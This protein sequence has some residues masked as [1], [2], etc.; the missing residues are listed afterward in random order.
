MKK[1]CQRPPQRTWQRRHY[2]EVFY[3]FHAE[4]TLAGQPLLTLPGLI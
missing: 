1:T 3:E 2:L 4:S